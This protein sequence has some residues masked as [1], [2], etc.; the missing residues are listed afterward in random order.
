MIKRQEIFNIINL[1]TSQP[2]INFYQTIFNNID[3]SSMPEF[4]NSKRG[5]KE[6]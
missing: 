4:I 1:F 6:Y 2:I 5:P 3:L